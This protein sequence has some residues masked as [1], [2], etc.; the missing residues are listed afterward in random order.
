M[1]IKHA[2]KFIVTALLMLH[3]FVRVQAQEGTREVLRVTIDIRAAAQTIQH[4]G[5]SGCWYSESIGKYWPAEKKER[6]AELLF[7][8]KMDTSGNPA[9]IGLSAFRFNIGGGTAEQGISSGIRDPNRRVE[10]FLNRDGT[11]DWSKQSGYQWFLKKAKEYGVENLVAFSNTPPVHFTAN[12]LGFKTEK[13]YRSNL[14]PEYYPAY[15][16]FLAE[17]VKH[18]KDIGMPFSYVSPVNEP[19]WDWT[20]TVGSAKQEG[21]PWTNREIYSVL[22]TLDS[23]LKAKKL[24]TKITAPEAA[25]LSFLYSGETAASRQVQAFFSK[26][27]S[28]HVSDLK[29]LPRAVAGHSYFTDNGDTMLVNTRKALADTAKKYGVDFW[30]SE[31]S[32]LGEGFREGT[33]ERRTQMDCALFLAK[34]IHADLSIANATAWHLWNAYEPGNP[35]FDTRY[36]LVALKPDSGFLNGSYTVT[37][38][39]WALGHYSL[40]I[41]PGTHRLNVERSDDRNDIKAAQDVMVSAYKNGRK[42]IIIVA[43]NYTKEIR[44]MQVD[45]KKAKPAKTIQSYVTTASP[46]DNMRAVTLK[47]ISDILVLPPRSITTLVIN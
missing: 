32:M 6:I 3:V 35:L 21:T 42:R 18:F 1:N 10:C 8:R 40:F 44:Q 22:R 46:A 16:Q 17:V 26:E 29:T 41:R 43:V 14:R 12:G 30:Q 5:A 25:T 23:A 15:A 24:K 33:G 37:K 2:Y 34:V 20:G 31:Y 45:L 4:I 19:Q 9:G 27:S 38:N 39:L 47:N 28:L 11:Y 13:D 7:S 36:F